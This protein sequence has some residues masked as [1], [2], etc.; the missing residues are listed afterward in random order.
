MLLEHLFVCFVHVRFFNF[1]LPLNVGGC[2]RFVIVALPGLFIN[3]FEDI[4]IYK[5]L[6]V[7]PTDKQLCLYNSSCSTSGGNGDSY[8]CLGYVSEGFMRRNRTT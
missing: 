4:H 7:K 5:D 8:M 6:Y 2:M 3:V 1:S